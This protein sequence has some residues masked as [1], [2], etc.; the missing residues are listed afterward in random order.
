VAVIITQ[1]PFSTCQVK[2]YNRHQIDISLY[3]GL[4]N[5]HS[6]KKKSSINK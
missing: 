4:Q 3:M 2:T 6:E 1:N 5:V